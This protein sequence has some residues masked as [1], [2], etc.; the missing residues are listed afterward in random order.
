MTSS[1]DSKN[2]LTPL[3]IENPPFQT[4]SSPGAS[5]IPSE[6]TTNPYL[7]AAT[8]NN[9]RK[10]Y[11]A[12]I[13][14]FEAWGGTLPATSQDIVTY[15][16]AF[17]DTLNPRTLSR[18]LTAFK[19]W[20]TYQGFEDPTSNPLVRKTLKGI[21]NVHG[22]PK[23]KASPL[24]PEQLQQLVM[25]LEQQDTL[26]A[27]RDNA[28]LQIGFFGAFRR[29]ELI[30]IQYE[31]IERSKEGI[32]ILIPRSKTD[33]AGEGQRCAIPYGHQRLCPIRALDVWLNRSRIIKGPVFR[34]ITRWGKMGDEPLT[35]I[36]VTQI[37]KK[38]ATEC[39]LDN[40]DA[41]SSHSL[42]RGLAT[43]ASQKG[44][45]LKAI[46]R[47]GRWQHVSTVLGY[48]EDGQ[49]FG[50]NAAATVLEEIT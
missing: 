32:E 4:L 37:I 19:H 1:T 38:R 17:A 47:Q 39:G 22:T 40:A 20:H 11:R 43:T 24:T 49:R 8:A 36:A 27:Y 2:Q 5:L 45:S 13:H 42:R 7:Q 30:Q 26:I 9:T 12:D 28:L 34:R 29:S 44:A 6:T 16:Q 48:I 31:Y 23:I 41:L 46:M 50:D 33:Q 35:P 18:R 10:A 21:M 25:H 15:L 14:H 3:P